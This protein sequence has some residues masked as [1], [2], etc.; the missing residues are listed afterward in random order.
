MTAQPLAIPS[1][2]KLR[3]ETLLARI[4]DVCVSACVCAFVCV[5]VFVVCY[6]CREQQERDQR[7]AERRERGLSGPD[8]A[9]SRDEDAYHS[10][11]MDVGDPASTNL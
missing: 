1:C 3:P 6:G 10:G 2:T 11:V 7:E 9:Y 8:P 5:C 4:P